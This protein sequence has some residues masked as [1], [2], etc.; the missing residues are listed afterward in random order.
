M[1]CRGTWHSA[2]KVSRT[3][4]PAVCS[5]VW[6]CPYWRDCGSGLIGFHH[7]VSPIEGCHHDIGGHGH[8]HEDGRFPHHPGNGPSVHCPCVL[9]AWSIRVAIVSPGCAVHG[10]WQMLLMELKFYACH[11][12][13]HHPETDGSMERLN[14]ILEQ[15]L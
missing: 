2:C 9:A 13:A 11:S 10:F 14:A 4:M 7:R 15:Y 8:A 1:M 5:L 12:S 3:N 6:C